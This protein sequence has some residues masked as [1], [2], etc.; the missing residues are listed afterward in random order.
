MNLTPQAHQALSLSI[1]RDLRVSQTTD[2]STAGRLKIDNHTAK[3]I[4][5]E[6]VNDDLA[7]TR[8]I[9]NTITVYHI[10]AAGIELLS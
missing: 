2:S 10:T 3:A 9:N 8:S 4:L 5:S 7:A 6:L 1:L